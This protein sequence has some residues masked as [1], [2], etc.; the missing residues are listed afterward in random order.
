MI[1]AFN[2]GII[3]VQKIFWNIKTKEELECAENEL[4]ELIA[5]IGLK[6]CKYAKR[7]E[8]RYHDYYQKRDRILAWLDHPE[9][10]IPKTRPLLAIIT[11]RKPR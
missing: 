9:L 3:I 1:S 6:T 4:N 10:N 11:A 7:I 5:R 2:S 8:K